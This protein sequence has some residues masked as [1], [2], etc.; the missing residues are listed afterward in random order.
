MIQTLM[1]QHQAEIEK[2]K[3]QQQLKDVAVLGKNNEH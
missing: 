3:W 1:K 2:I